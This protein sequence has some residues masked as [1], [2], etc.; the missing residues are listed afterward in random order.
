MMRS[1]SA[2]RPVRMMIGRSRDSRMRRAI[3]R[4]SSSGSLRSRI[5]RST[6][7]APS[8][9]SISA[10]VSAMETLKSCSLRYSLTSSRMAASSSTT[11][12]WA[13]MGRILALPRRI[14]GDRRMNAPSTTIAGP[15][16]SASVRQLLAFV[17]FAVVYYLLAAYAVSLPFPTRF[18]VLIWPGH[19]LA[20]GV[21]LV[22]A[23][24]RW[25]IYLLLIA[26]A[27]IAVGFALNAPWQRIAASVAVNLAQ[28][29]FAA[30]GL[31]RVAGPLVQIDTGGRL[32]SGF[33][34]P[35]LPAPAVYALRAPFP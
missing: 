1:A 15:E 20:L 19:G 34:G 32:G 27:T 4:P 23:V 7:S 9:L 18:P 30:A 13:S 8:T 17:T 21:L 35:G 2:L 26:L 33:G 29:P 31:Q 5:T 3:D 11:R 28:P 16:N 10:P 14:G 24:R 25:P 12:I 22:A 6:I